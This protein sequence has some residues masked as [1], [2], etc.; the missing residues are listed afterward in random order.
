MLR[1]MDI[2]ANVRNEAAILVGKRGPESEYRRLCRGNEKG[3]VA[4]L[5]CAIF[6]HNIS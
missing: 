6:A 3:K 4:E 1:P 2:V 5:S